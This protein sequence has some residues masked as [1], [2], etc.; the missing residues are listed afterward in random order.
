MLRLTLAPVRRGKQLL[1]FFC[2]VFAKSSICYASA[3][4]LSSAVIVMRNQ[5]RSVVFILTCGVIFAG[6]G[7]THASSDNDTPLSDFIWID[8]SSTILRDFFLSNWSFYKGCRGALGTP[9]EAFLKL[10]AVSDGERMILPTTKSVEGYVNIKTHGQALSFVRLFTDLDTHYLFDNNEFIEVRPAQ[11]T[12]SWGELPLAQFQ[13]LGLKAPS[14]SG[15]GSCF[16]ID[17]YLVDD[18]RNIYLVH[19]SVSATGAYMIVSKKLVAA[20]T[21]VL[22]PIYE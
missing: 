6:F 15:V 14:V 2:S 13:K 11:N 18:D 19:E 17:R 16:F 21:S 22:I 4:Q 9:L 12:P 3:P 20:G 5:I 7:L 8:K 10:V 1:S